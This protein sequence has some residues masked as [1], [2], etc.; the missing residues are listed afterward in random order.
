MSDV[1]AD[2]AGRVSSVDSEARC[3][4]TGEV[5][6]L[7]PWPVHNLGEEMQRALAGEPSDRV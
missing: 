3:V 6:V 7:L 4:V 5:S 1:R 2:L